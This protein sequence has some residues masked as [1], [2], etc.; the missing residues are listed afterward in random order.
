MLI[1]K[2]PYSDI[3]P[4][5]DKFFDLY[6]EK[7]QAQIDRY[8]QAFV[9]FKKRFNY[10]EAYVASSSGRVEVCGNHT[11]HNGGRVVSCAISLDSLAFF[12]PNNT[13]VI[14]VYSQGYGE[15]CVDLSSDTEIEVGT[16]AS[17]IK[18]V[19]VGLV[20]YGFKTGGFDAYLTSNV[21]GG[22]GISS[23]ASFETL[24]C[25]ILSFLYNDNK[26]SKKENA[27]ISQYA[28]N[29]YF[30]KPC[31][32]LD[33]TAIAF[34]GLKKLDFKNK[35]EI[36]VTDINCDLSGYTLVLIN[37]GGSHADLTEEYAAIPREMKQV[38]SLFGKERLIEIEDYEF[39]D[40]IAKIKDKV[41]DRAL[42]RAFHF[43]EENSRVDGL[44]L[45]L[46]NSDYI[47]FLDLIKQSGLS[48]MWKLQN[49]M[50]PSSND[51]LIP[52]A[53]AIS[54]KYLINGANRV[55]GGGFAGTILNVIDNRFSCVFIE[56][57]KE[58]F[59]EEKVLPLKVR[60]VGVCVL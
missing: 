41:S 43:Y 15:I 33:Q 29:V 49:C 26:V 32:L 52:R 59:G 17:L 10:D 57:M 42:L 47:S 20:N 50:I 38:A 24:V 45:A 9:E 25:E 21:V 4:V 11:D 6:G 23:S 16:S 5:F 53:L 48:S 18:G 3:T 31:G 44:V 54:S 51:Q 19:A 40:N 46:E 2:N 30:G 35:G 60:K 8:T 12:M 7:S 13:N 27:I 56:K 37:T 55:H 58:I 14:R 36:E 22:A 34:G 39:F 1:Q 28:E